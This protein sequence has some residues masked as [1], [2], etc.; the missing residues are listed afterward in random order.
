MGSQ[1]GYDHTGWELA[2]GVSLDDAAVHLNGL[3]VSTERRDGALHLRDP[4]GHG[5]ELVPFDASDDPAPANRPRDRHVPGFHP[6][7]LGHVNFL[8]DDL[9]GDD[10]VLLRRAGHA[11]YRS[12]R[13]RGHV[14]AHQCRPPLDG[15]GRQGLPPSASPGF[16]LSTGASCGWRLT[17]WPSTA[18][19]W[20]GVR[21]ATAWVATW[22]PTC[23]SP[24][25]SASSSCSATWSSWSADH[26]P[27]DWPDERHSS[28]TWGILPPRSYFRF[29][30]AAVE[31]EREGLEALGYPLPAM[32]GS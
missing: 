29:D 30:A 19:G 31:A 24:R 2:R 1:P 9:A 28:N 10:R 23:A 25:R 21:C 17:I 16:E 18:G 12:A 8:T 15:A 14:A 26:Q 7:K 3:G 27:R 4:D 13:R 6:R 22:P 20:A 32:G 11:G 5:V